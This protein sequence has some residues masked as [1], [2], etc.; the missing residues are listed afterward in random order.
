[1]HANASAYIALA[2][3]TADWHHGN[4]HCLLGKDL[5]DYNFLSITKEG[6]VLMSVQ[7]ASEAQLDD[8]IF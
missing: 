7:L 4:A 8:V 2:N 5:T 1:V 6:F 3:A